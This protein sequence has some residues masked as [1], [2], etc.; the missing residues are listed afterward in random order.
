MSRIWYLGVCSTCE[1]IL[2]LLPGDLEKQEIRSDP[3]RLAR[4]RPYLD[5]MV[6]LSGSHESLFSR[7]AMKYRQ[8]GLHEKTL[9]ESDYRSLLLEHDTF[10]K[11]PVAIVEDE[12]FVGSSKKT[13]QALVERLQG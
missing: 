8:L 10:L 2:N 11:R 4:P 5:Q 9:K 7:R 12:I 6:S 13:V 3:R 1:K